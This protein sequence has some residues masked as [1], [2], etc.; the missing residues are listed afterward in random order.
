MTI[1]PED[2]S[3]PTQLREVSAEWNETNGLLA[4]G[5]DRSVGYVWGWESHHGSD[6]FDLTERVYRPGWGACPD[7]SDGFVY[8]TT[9][10]DDM[11]KVHILDPEDHLRHVC[12]T[13]GGVSAVPNHWKKEAA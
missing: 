8:V 10:T 5:A 12:T 13:C 3:T 7:C 2:I 6:P 4:Y 1:N 9:W 11:G